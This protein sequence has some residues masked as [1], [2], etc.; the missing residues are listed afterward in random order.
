MGLEDLAL[1][2]DIQDKL[3]GSIKK[4][5]GVKASR[6]RQLN[7]EGMIKLIN[8]INSYIRHSSRLLQLHCVAQQ[9]NISVIEPMLIDRSSQWFAGFFDAD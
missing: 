8:C 3:R 6:Y 4:R 7:R 2:R 5:S 1:L 9:L